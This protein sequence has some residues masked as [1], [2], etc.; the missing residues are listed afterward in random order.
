MS[1]IDRHIIEAV[2]SK[3]K[4]SEKQ[5]FVM[6][7]PK[8][9]SICRRYANDDHEAKDYLQEVYIRLFDKIHLFDENKASFSTWFHTLATNRILELKRRKKI[10]YELPSVETAESEAEEIGYMDTISREQLLAA[11]SQLPEGYRNVTHLF[12]FEKYS[13][14]EIAQKLN[15]TESTSRSQFT[16]AKRLLKEI[17]QESIP[18]NYERRLA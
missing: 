9:F 12:V 1:T 8:V 6:T 2:K 10:F 15:I 11:I 18:K 14:K 7:A 3:D 13:H 5:L 16:R 4:K 17:L